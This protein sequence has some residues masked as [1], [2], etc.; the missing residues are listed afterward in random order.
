MDDRSKYN[1]PFEDAKGEEGIGDVLREFERDIEHDFAS[2]TLDG[3]S[4]DRQSVMEVLG[5]NC[6]VCGSYL[7]TTGLVGQ[8]VSCEFSAL[9][10][11]S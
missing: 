6:P 11:A 4:D 3:R 7:I 8:E 9:K 5:S 10:K 2:D 1:D